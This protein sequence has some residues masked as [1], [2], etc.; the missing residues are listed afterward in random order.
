M[1]KTLLTALAAVMLVVSAQGVILARAQEA[2]PAQN[3]QTQ[4]MQTE[5]GSLPG[6]VPAQSSAVDSMTPALH[7]VVLAMLNHE[8]AVFDSGDP[9][10]GWEALYNMLSLYGQLDERSDYVGEDLVLPVET[11]MDFSAALVPSF[12]QLGGLPEDL[13]D[14]LAYDEEIDSYLVTCGSD[15][16]AQIQV[17]QMEN[18]NGTLNVTGALV[19]LVDGSDLAQFRAVLAPRD[20]MFGYT[21]AEMELL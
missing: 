11:V 19:Y 2:V 8:Q 6:E 16:L 4:A 18:Q 17:T 10:L 14:R 1:K 7:A 21:I 3:A 9:V 5:E 20:N 13:S 12:S 15:S